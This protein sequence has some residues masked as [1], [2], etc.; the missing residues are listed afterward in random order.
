MSATVDDIWYSC[1]FSDAALADPAL[2]RIEAQAS[3]LFFSP[4]SARMPVGV[5]LLACAKPTKQDLSLLVGQASSWTLLF[6]ES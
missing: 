6:P 3:A 5:D 1:N 4:G 2:G